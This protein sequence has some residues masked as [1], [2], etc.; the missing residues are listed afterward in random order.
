MEVLNGV[1]DQINE[2]SSTKRRL[3]QD[4]KEAH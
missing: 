4:T 3:E 2:K 1:L